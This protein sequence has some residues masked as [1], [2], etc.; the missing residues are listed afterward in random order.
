[1]KTPFLF[2]LNH[3]ILPFQQATAYI[4]PLLDRFILTS[5]EQF[6]STSFDQLISP[7]LGHFTITP[8]NRFRMSEVQIRASLRIRDLRLRTPFVNFYHNGSFWANTH[9]HPTPRDPITSPSRLEHEATWITEAGRGSRHCLDVAPF[10]LWNNETHDYNDPTLAQAKWIFNTYSATTVDFTAPYIVITTETPSH[11]DHNGLVTL[12]VGCAPAIFV[13]KQ[14]QLDGFY[15]VP[16]QPNALNYCHPTMPDPLLENFQTQPYTEPSVQ[17][18]QIILDHLR[19]YCSVHAL[20]F[21]FPEL[22]VEL[23]NYDQVYQPQSLPSRLGGW[24]I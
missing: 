1:M 11:P 15:A 8:G 22:I 2:L 19:K 3:S 12:T 9:S 20:N 4:S 18:A 24:P 23:A 17:E 6:I 14:T 13:S 5:L 10:S 7:S 21:I 16:P